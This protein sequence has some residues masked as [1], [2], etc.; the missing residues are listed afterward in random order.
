MGGRGLLPHPSAHGVEAPLAEEA[1]QYFERG[2]SFFYRWLPFQYASAATR[3]LPIVYDE[4]RKLAA[5]R[6][7]N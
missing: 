7:A 4:L 2:P 6:M 5:A 1:L 3:L